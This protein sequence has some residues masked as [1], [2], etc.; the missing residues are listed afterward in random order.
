[1]EASHSTGIGPMERIPVYEHS[2]RGRATRTSAPDDRGTRRIAFRSARL[3][4]ESPGVYEWR[5]EWRVA[6]GQKTAA[7]GGNDLV[8]CTFTAR[9]TAAR[10]CVTQLERARTRSG[11]SRSRTRARRLSL[12]MARD[13]EPFERRG[14]SLRRRRRRRSRHAERARTTRRRRR[15][16]VAEGVPS[17]ESLTLRQCNQ[18]AIRRFSGHARRRIATSRFGA[19]P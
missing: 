5:F 12:R 18:A 17:P 3:A 6:T 19:V 4:P 1:M 13:D 10:A 15:E 14:Q 8:R 11:S 9:D 16:A 2:R 7:A